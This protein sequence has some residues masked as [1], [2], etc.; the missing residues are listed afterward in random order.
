[1]RVRIPA[2]T[3]GLQ[4]C[5]LNLLERAPS[6]ITEKGGFIKERPH[7]FGSK[8][9]VVDASGRNPEESSAI[10]GAPAI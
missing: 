10:L 9:N 8:A 3:V 5:S 1:M 7:Y 2:G 4:S 6:S